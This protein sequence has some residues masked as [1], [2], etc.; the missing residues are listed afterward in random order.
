MSGAGIFITQIGAS[1]PTA[2][3]YQFVFNSDWPSLQTAFEK[4]VVVPAGG[5]VV[6]VLHRLGFFPLTFVFLTQ[7]NQFVGRADIGNTD[8]AC[9]I[10]KQGLY[11]TNNNV[12]SSYTANIKCYNLDL[13]KPH[14]YTLPKFP[15]VNQPYDPTVGIKV[16][17]YGKDIHSTDLRDFILHSRAQSP[18]LLS[19]VT[20]RSAVTSPLGGGLERISYTNP[21]GYIPWI[22]GY[23]GN[24][25]TI[26]E[27]LVYNAAGFSVQS[28][29][30]T[31]NPPATTLD[32]NPATGG[33]TLIILR[34]PLIL[35]NP[36]SVNFNSNPLIGDFETP[37]TGNFAYNPVG[38]L[39]GWSFLGLAGVA[40]NGSAF[41]N[42]NAYSGTQVCFLQEG[43]KI[44]LSYNFPFT[45]DYTLGFVMAWRLGQINPIAIKIDGSTITTYT[46]PGA[47]WNPSQTPSFHVAA[48]A[49]TISFE[50]TVTSSDVTTFVDYITISGVASG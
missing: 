4:T 8:V 37:V 50:G 5:A 40:T 30:L 48:G 29:G 21:A 38:N 47:G 20:E 24:N 23:I 11:L 34:D 42:P 3:D 43:G 10:G 1:V 45:G 27:S 2:A 39:E 18:A 7:N 31:I 15:A 33:A 13:Q 25:G 14:D 36:V 41:N 6:T 9:F 12:S 19:V 26:Y 44:T 49:H 22:G 46:V 17:K 16:A 35:P 32:F 28:P